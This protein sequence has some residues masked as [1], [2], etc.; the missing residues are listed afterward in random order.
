M[1]T[2]PTTGVRNINLSAVAFFGLTVHSLTDMGSPSHVSPNGMPYTW[3]NVAF[4][5][6][7]HIPAEREDYVDWFD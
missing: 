7:A 2:C 4:E 6:L 1:R 5:G 3:S